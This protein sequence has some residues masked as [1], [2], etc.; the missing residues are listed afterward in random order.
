MGT[1]NHL[2]QRWE[3]KDSL[4]YTLIT[5]FSHFLQSTSFL[6][7]C[8]FLFIIECN[9]CH[10]GHSFAIYIQMVPTGKKFYL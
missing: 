7:N 6:Q 9:L 10:Q 2:K 4:Y 8:T 5:I 1:D 3:E